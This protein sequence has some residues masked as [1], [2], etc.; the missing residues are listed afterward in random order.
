MYEKRMQD[1]KDGKPNVTF[2][3]RKIGEMVPYIYQDDLILLSGQSKMGKSSAAH[4]IAMVNARRMKVL[5]FHNEDNP[6]KLFLRRIAQAQYMKDPSLSG[7]DNSG[8]DL[9]TLKY[10]ELLS[11]GMRDPKML[12]RLRREQNFIHL[13]IGDNIIYVYCPGWTADRI[14]SMWRSI[15]MKQDIGLVIIDY[16]NKIESYEKAKRL[17]TMPYAM[18]YNVELFKREAGRK[19]AMTPCVV[20][21][22]ENE[23]GTTR[24]TRSS[25]IKSQVHISLGR[26]QDHNGLIPDG[27]ITV[28]RANDGM[29][30][31]VRAQFYADYMVWTT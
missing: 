14:T 25:Y 17:G 8:I 12:E 22:Q 10:P 3:W 16:L 1:I 18:E 24:D 21:Q 5:Y 7:L 26:D 2:P 28:K 31:G 23:D 6:M 29:T 30:G 19:T 9:Y 11:T 4:Q 27:W 13:N 20:V 15:R